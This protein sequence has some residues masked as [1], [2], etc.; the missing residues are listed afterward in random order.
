MP[1]ITKE[2]NH[3]YENNLDIDDCI[4]FP[5][6]SG[7]RIEFDPECHTESGCDPLKFY[8]SSGR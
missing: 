2:S 4:S 6:A 7:L 5:G 1:P 8:S 3:P